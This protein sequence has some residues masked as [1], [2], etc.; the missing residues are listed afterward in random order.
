MLETYQNYVNGK[1]VNASTSQTFQDINPADKD[2]VV[3]LFQA[4]S[5]EDVK[6][7][8]QAAAEEFSGWA[9][10]SG[11]QR[12]SFL[13]KAADALESRL[14]DVAR[15]LSRE[16]GKTLM[17]ARGETARGVTI[18]RYYAAEVMNPQGDVI[19]SVNAKSLVYTSRV[20]LG[21]VAVITP[22]NFPIA[23]PLWKIAP[24]LAY[25]NTVVFKPASLAP[26]TGLNV[27]KALQDGGLP[28]GVL[29]MVTGS[30]ASTGEELV[31]N[32]FIKGV[33]FTGSNEIGREIATWAVNKGAKFQL[34]MGGKNPVIVMPDCDMDQAVE[35]T[36]SGAMRSAGQ[37][38]T[39][40]SRA[41]VLDDILEEF[42]ERVVDRVKQLKLGP[43]TDESAYLGP[44]VSQE[45]QQRVLTYIERGKG[46]G[47]LLLAGGKALTGAPFDQGFYVE[48][49]VFGNVNED[50]IISQDEIFGPVLCITSAANL[51]H[52]LK[53]A[54]GVRY[55]LS[56]SLF[57]RDL[58]AA[59][60][61]ARRIDAGL[62]RI[63]G[64][65]SG[66]EPQ[67]PF[68][69]MKASSS[70]SREQG[71]SA[72]EFYTEIKTVYIDPA[73]R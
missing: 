19:P 44:L 17:E 34:E 50:M 65:T 56:A 49:T 51:D 20:P 32:P 40:T 54:N 63:N 12:G 29:N 52:A 1:W 16:E 24:A 33:S 22:W 67:A 62:V 57:T 38:C 25:G 14:E 66:V 55:G 4:S 10:L 2:D 31:K 48:P 64:E 35:L 26:L 18:L 61:F 71:Q 70:H 69:G 13:Y 60:E 27:V 59:M 11:P 73:G 68:G 53:I 23:I 58:N 39:A 43:A 37:K 42:T 9:A 41:I 36:V 15:S 5:R 46:Q 45:Q 8:A 3:G 72:K 28:P 6:H 21:P 47:A 30:G 7:A